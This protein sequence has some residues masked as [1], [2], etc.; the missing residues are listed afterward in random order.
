MG[1]PG[2]KLEIDLSGGAIKPRLRQVKSIKALL[3]NH[4]AFVE[5]FQVR[6]GFEGEHV[7]ELLPACSRGSG[8]QHSKTVSSPQS[9]KG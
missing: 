2:C 9:D 6:E 8:L 3:H 1:G 4:H 5:I 7:R